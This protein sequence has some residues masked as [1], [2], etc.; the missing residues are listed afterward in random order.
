M[1]PHA[2]MRRRGAAILTLVALLGLVVLG[3]GT[4]A[5]GE[6][7][8]APLG[9]TESPAVTFDGTNYFVVWTDYTSGAGDIN[10]ARVAPDGTVLDA[11][12]GIPISTAASQQVEPAVGFDGTNYLVVWQDRRTDDIYDI[13]GARV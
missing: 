3:L 8:A 11:G 9:L 13:Y 5:R 1:S 12:P 7:S 4:N 2:R 6:S 10:G